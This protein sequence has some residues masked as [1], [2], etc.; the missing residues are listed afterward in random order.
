M[1]LNSPM[2]PA[3]ARLGEFG[4]IG[5]IRQRIQERTSG[6]IRGIG[7]DAAVLA[8]DPGGDLLVTTDMLLEGIHFQRGWDCLRELGRKAMAVNVSDI[9]AMGGCPLYALLG[10]AMPAVGITLAEVEALLLGLEEEAATHGITLVGG[11]TCVS[12]SGLVISV[13]LL[14]RSPRG[15]A[16]LRSGAKPGDWLWVTGG[17]GGAAAGLLALEQGFRPGQVWPA[18]LSR[19]D[20]LGGEEE[21]AIQEALAAHLTPVPRL[22]AGRAL[23][24]I[25]T[26]MID[27][28][29]GVAS[30]AGHLCTESRVAARIQASQIPIHRGAAVMARL[31]GR[32][33]LDLALRGGEDYELLFTAD[34]DPVP[35][36]AEAAPTLPVTW[37]GE[38][39]PGT[40]APTLVHADGREEHLAGGFDHFRK[41]PP[42]SARTA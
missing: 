5:L 6:T 26:A 11:D 10:L 34:S 19:P 21:A 15:G 17:L 9:A 36:L 24:G 30:D 41:A 31:L 13:T 32:E 27:V 12:A 23:Q 18:T 35:V 2:D 28:S 33:A 39:I 8:A 4:L 40:P 14:G 3:L 16:V 42:R 1:E 37:V 22:A 25:A 38:I 7:D 20:W 29:D